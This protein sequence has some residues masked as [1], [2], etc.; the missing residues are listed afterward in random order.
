MESYKAK[1]K[2]STTRS[3][4]GVPCLEWQGYKDKDGYGRVRIS[5]KKIGVHRLAYKQH[6]GEIPEML[7]VL[8]R[9]DNPPCGEYSHLFTGTQADNV[10]DMITKGRHPIGARN[11]KFTKPECTPRGATHWRNKRKMAA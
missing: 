4:N 6:F 8:H 7:H 5:G 2:T 10:R 11:G 9:C 1:W 3:F